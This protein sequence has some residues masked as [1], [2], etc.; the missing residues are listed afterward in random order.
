MLINRKIYLLINIAFN[1]II[2]NTCILDKFYIYLFSCSQGL[3]EGRATLGRITH[4]LVRVNSFCFKAEIDFSFF[5]LLGGLVSFIT[6]FFSFFLLFFFVFFL[7]YLK[8]T[9]TVFASAKIAS[10]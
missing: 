3:S 7:I 9:L 2:N 6:F 8:K 4:P 10:R 5:F 1:E